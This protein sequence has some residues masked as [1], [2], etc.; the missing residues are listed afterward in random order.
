MEEFGYARTEAPKLAGFGSI[1]G[2]IFRGFVTVGDFL[3]DTGNGIVN[4]GENFVT[5]MSDHLQFLM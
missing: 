4:G 3:T 2:K 5:W 1:P